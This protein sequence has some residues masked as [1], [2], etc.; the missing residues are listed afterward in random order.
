MSDLPN[1]QLINKLEKFFFLEL[2]SNL[3]WRTLENRHYD[4]RLEMFYKIVCGLVAIPIPSYF[5]R[6][7][8]YI[9]HMHPLGWNLIQTLLWLTDKFTRLS[10]IINIYSFPWQL[11][12]GTGYQ[13]ILS[14]ILILTNYFR[15]S[16]SQLDPGWGVGRGNYLYR[17]IS[18]CAENVVW[19][20]RLRL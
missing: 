1:L 15:F 5:E 18:A 7:E 19:V 13:L 3:G 20:F 2:M 10:G 16:R 12:S 4:A 8:V 11:F 9:R 6:P 14:S 17:G